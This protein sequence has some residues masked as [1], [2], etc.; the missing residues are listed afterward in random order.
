MPKGLPSFIPPHS[1]QLLLIAWMLGKEE[2][3]EEGEGEREGVRFSFSEVLERWLCD[4]L[5]PSHL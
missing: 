4:H 3:E 5:R 2:E 1:S